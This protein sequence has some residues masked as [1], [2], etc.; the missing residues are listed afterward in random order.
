M[1][2]V[3]ELNDL[4]EAKTML[5][6][7]DQ[8]FLRSYEVAKQNTKQVDFVKVMISCMRKFHSLAEK[9]GEECKKHPHINHDMVDR[10]VSHDGR[11]E[12]MIA[13]LLYGLP[14]D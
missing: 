3:I 5:M 10:F 8:S 14:N 1:K 4:D 7:F 6:A 13:E 12:K 9:V 2:I 11:W